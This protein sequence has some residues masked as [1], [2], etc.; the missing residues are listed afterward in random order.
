MRHKSSAPV[1][2]LL[3]IIF[4]IF[5]VSTSSIFIRF[6]QNEAPSLVIAASRL[7]IAT[8]ILAPVAFFRNRQE[9]L[10]IR[11]NHLL[12]AILS[13]FFLAL[14]F[15]SWISSLEFTSVASSVVLVSTSPLWVAFLSPFI[16]RERVTQWIIIGLLLASLGSVIIGVSDVCHLNST[17]L[18]CPP[19]KE[20]LQG[21]A[22]KGDILALAG[23]LMGASYMMIGRRLRASLSVVSYIFLVYGAAAIILIIIMLMAGL[24]PLGYSPLTYFLFLL[25][26]IVPQLLGHSSF[27]WAL[28]YLSAAFVS[29]T[30]LGEPVG[31]TILAYII[32][33][34]TPDLIKIIGAI[35][36][37]IGIALAS[38]RAS[39]V[40]V[41][42]E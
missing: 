40:K 36:I 1:P 29:I 42:T 32:L 3:V 31:S 27:N 10:Q 28:G 7:T 25:L 35:L 9:L 18:V 37:L 16:L 4:G 17:Q 13:G 5:A 15:A 12:L 38:I 26:A 39:A 6:A 33:D 23:A 41:S 19:I 14:H 21:E 24:S 2:P 8:L 22:F 30:L 20:F 34:E 11:R